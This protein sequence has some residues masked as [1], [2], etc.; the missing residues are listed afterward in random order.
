MKFSKR[1][2]IAVALLIP[3][4]GL[5]AAVGYYVHRKQATAAELT[6]LLAA[7]DRDDPGWR[8]LEL[9]QKRTAI[10]PK[11]DSGP[12]ILKLKRQVR[13]DWWKDDEAAQSPD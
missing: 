8:L 9:E 6:E 2:V 13:R 1:R 4:L 10:P 5:L 3:L 11:Q 12:V 7:L